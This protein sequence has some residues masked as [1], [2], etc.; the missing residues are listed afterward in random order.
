VAEQ[1]AFFDQL[2]MIVK[3]LGDEAAAR[4]RIGDCRIAVAV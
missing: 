2:P 3:A 4:S 1:A